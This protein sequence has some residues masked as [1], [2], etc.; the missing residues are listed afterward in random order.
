MLEEL[1]SLTP[2][3]KKQVLVVATIIIM[4]IIVGVWVTYFNSIVMGTAP[5][6]ATQATSTDATATVPIAIT[7]TPTASTP[8]TTAQASGSGIWQDIKNGFASF[9]HLFS[10]PSQYKIQ[11]QSN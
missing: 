1:Q 8:A 5:Q 10:N 11:P 6:V 4:I 3:K 2:A 7:P 9:T